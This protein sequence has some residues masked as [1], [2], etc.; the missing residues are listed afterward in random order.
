MRATAKS[1]QKAA[2]RLATRGCLC[3]LGLPSPNNVLC[4]GKKVVGRDERSRGDGGVLVDYARLDQTLDGLDGGSVNDTA[5]SADRIGA[6]DDVAADRGVLHDGGSNHD[7]IV[8]RACE[9]LDDEVDHLA[10][11]GIFI[12]EELGDAK[13]EGGGFLP[14]PAL[15]GEEQQGEL[16]EDLADMSW[17]L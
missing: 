3:S 17:D 6:V 13:E 7:D 11:R 16:G 12:L 14:A 8:G 1:T 2:A 9:L 15:A 4:D 10:E 5:E